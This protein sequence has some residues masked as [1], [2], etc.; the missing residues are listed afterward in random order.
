MASRALRLRW[1]AQCSSCGE[2][3]AKG[4]AVEWDGDT[5]TATCEACVTTRGAPAAGTGTIESGVAGASALRQYERRSARERS[6]KEAIV[7][8]DAARRE[9]AVEQHPVLG[10]VV[11]ALTPKSVVGP[12]SQRTRAWAKGSAGEE[13]LGG[14]L[15]AV[16]SAVV[17]HDRRMPAS[18]ANIDHIAVSA[19]GVFV[20]DAK[21]YH[22]VVEKRDLGGWLRRDERLFVN[23]RDRTKN[24]DGVLDQ[25]VAVR[26][27]LNDGGFPVEVVPLCGVL[28]FVGPNWRRF[29]PRP[30]LVRG[31]E[32]VWPAKAVAVV[33]QPGPLTPEGVEQVARHL[34]AALAPA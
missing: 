22:G 29:F 5:K 18:R 24:I 15:D 32:V 3:L 19:A 30:L 6:R 9:R 23:G 12:E 28:C 16:G 11:T 2:V 13:L 1:P 34:A 27:A 7:A 10:R 14:I 31:I 20:I 25:L 21:N 4:T 26:G 8:L 17:L 33:K